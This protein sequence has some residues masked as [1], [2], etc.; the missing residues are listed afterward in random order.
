MFLKTED[1]KLLNMDRVEKISYHLGGLAAGPQYCLFAAFSSGVEDIYIF[2]GEERFEIL[3]QVHA[4]IQK[5]QDAIVAGDA[6]F[7][8]PAL[9]PEDEPLTHEEAAEETFNRR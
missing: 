4:M 9:Y 2:R 1:G 7:D 5:I 3:M 6:I 8:V